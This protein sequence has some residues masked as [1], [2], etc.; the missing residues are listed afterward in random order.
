MRFQDCDDRKLHKQEHA[1]LQGQSCEVL[2]MLI[3]NSSRPDVLKDQWR[4]LCELR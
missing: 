1:G 3:I 2:Q 4:G